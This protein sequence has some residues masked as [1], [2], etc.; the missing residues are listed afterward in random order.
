[1]TENNQPGHIDCLLKEEVVVLYILWWRIFLKMRKKFLVLPLGR[2]QPTQNSQV[3]PV[4]VFPL[5]PVVG[6][7]VW[8]P[9]QD[10]QG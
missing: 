4:L 7:V 1:M 10:F 3:S 9:R 6:G 2:P 8:G 5:S